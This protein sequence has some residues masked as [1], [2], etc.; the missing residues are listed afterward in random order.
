MTETNDPFEPIAGHE[1]DA[2]RSK[3]A[4][5]HE[6]DDVEQYRG[7]ESDAPQDTGIPADPYEHEPHNP[8]LPPRDAG[9]DEG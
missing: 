3:T 1:V 9:T 7:D 5:E 8:D 4:G 2:P 6:T